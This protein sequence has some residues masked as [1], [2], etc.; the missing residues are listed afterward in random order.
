[1][2]D[3]FDFIVKVLFLLSAIFCIGIAGYISH[4]DKTN[5]NWGWFLFISLCLAGFC[6]SY[7]QKPKKDN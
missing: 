4:F 1:M 3:F 5:N 6:L 7:D 2:K